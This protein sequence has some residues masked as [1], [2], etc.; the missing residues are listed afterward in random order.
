MAAR[1]VDHCMTGGLPDGEPA[2]GALVHDKAPCSGRYGSNASA[3]WEIRAR[4]HHHEH[5]DVGTIQTL[6]PSVG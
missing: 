4:N 1:M 5:C 6:A 3:G 2:R